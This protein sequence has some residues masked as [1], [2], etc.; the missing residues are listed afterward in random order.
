MAVLDS[1]MNPT[2]S[3]SNASALSNSSTSSSSDAK[4]AD[5]ITANDF[6]TLLVTELKNQDPTANKDP[7]EYVNQLCQINS[8]EELVSINSKLGDHADG[9]SAPGAA[10]SD[11]PQIPV[12]NPGSDAAAQGLSAYHANNL[13]NGPV[14]GAHAAA[15]APP[16][17]AIPA[18]AAAAASAP[19]GAVTPAATSL[20]VDLNP[21]NSV[22]P[23]VAP[24]TARVPQALN[25]QS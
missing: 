15:P 12:G 23:V 19:A 9:V 16:D 21:K 24:A 1:I 3:A 5:K 11:A 8:L 18:I 17:A 22:A 25:S 4:S 13:A 7:N 6:L 14:G 20:P 10:E 2:S